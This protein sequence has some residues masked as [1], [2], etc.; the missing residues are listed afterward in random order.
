MDKITI[1]DC[2]ISNLTLNET[3][4]IINA[5]I[6][7][8]RRI[9]HCCV[10]AAKIVS[11]KKNIELSNS[12]NECDIISAD[13]QSIVWASKILNSP[14][15]ERV[16]GIDLMNELIDLSSKDKHKIFF[17]GS[18]DEVI[19][20]LI[21][22]LNKCYGSEIVAGWN[23][24]Y[25]EASDE[26][27]IINKINRCNPDILFVGISSPK[28]EFF[29][30]KYKNKLNVPFLM[31]V[32]GSFDVFVGKVKRAPIWMQKSGLEWFYRFIKEPK[33][34]WKRYLYT[35]TIFLY[36]LLKEKLKINKG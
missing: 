10:N 16:A 24:G 31:G 13:G 9:T 5:A 2:L 28:K 29:L 18:T 14:L 11:M 27:R 3:V 1:F 6:K 36:R 4:D 33:R 32:G 25:F 34:M 17:L 8:N 7:N 12:I 22:K 15:K 20:K 19:D 35:N 30:N 26:V 23:N 21:S